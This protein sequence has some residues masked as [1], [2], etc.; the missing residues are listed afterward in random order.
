[1]DVDPSFHRGMK[2]EREDGPVVNGL[3]HPNPNPYAAVNGGVNGGYANGHG[4]LAA[5]NVV[6]EQQQP[7]PGVMNAKAGTGNIRPRPIKKQRMVGFVFCVG[8]LAID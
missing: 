2:R 5:A 1:M 4:A 6:H 8:F 7:K 3:V